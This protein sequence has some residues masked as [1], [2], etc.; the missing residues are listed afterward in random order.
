MV[1]LYTIVDTQYSSYTDRCNRYINRTYKPV[2]TIFEAL[3]LFKFIMFMIVDK[4]H[5]TTTSYLLDVGIPTTYYVL[6]L[7]LP[8]VLTTV[9]Y[10]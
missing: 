9:Q 3:S 8:V 1:Q 2:L 6:Y 10:R 5:R 7:L 4:P